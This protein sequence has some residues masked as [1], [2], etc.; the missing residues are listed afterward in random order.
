MLVGDSSLIGDLA[1]SIDAEQLLAAKLAIDARYKEIESAKLEEKRRQ[2]EIQR[3]AEEVQRQQRTMVAEISA[4][5][6]LKQQIP[7]SDSL[8]S[9]ILLAAHRGKDKVEKRELHAREVLAKSKANIAK[10]R[11]YLILFGTVI[12]CCVYCTIG[13]LQTQQGSLGIESR[14][15]IFFPSCSCDAS[16]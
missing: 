8:G 3:K 12:F 14:L 9:E 6:V 7:L 4:L 16:S 13:V 1:S 2:S 11:S 5:D 15:A 10:R